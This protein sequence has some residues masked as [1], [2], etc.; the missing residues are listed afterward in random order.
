MESAARRRTW[1]LV[2]LAAAILTT[3]TVFVSASADAPAIS[4]FQLDRIRAK[5]KPVKT[6]VL[7]AAV[8]RRPSAPVS[9]RYQAAPE[10]PE[11]N[12][13]GGIDW[14]PSK[15]PGPD[16]TDG[17]VQLPTL[18]VNAPIVRVGI[19]SEY[20][21]VVPHNARDVAWLD[22]GGI[23]GSTNNVVLAGHIAYSHVAGSFFRIG[24]LRPRDDVL[25]KMDGK[26][27]H[28]KVVWNC[29]FARDASA[30]LALKIMGYTDVPSVTL[31]SCGGGWDPVARTHTRRTA[32]RAE[33]WPPQKA[34]DTTA[35]K[36]PAHDGLLPA[37]RP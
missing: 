17:S 6:K 19:D 28:Y 36:H 2:A 37:G 35:E 1:G 31:I 32:V 16:P 26:T 25:L 9:G 13:P 18:G 22:Q 33:L 34:G 29:S 12:N 5:P 8:E 20:H 3:T 24:D 4:S 7:A 11:M 30:D 27:W 14:S 21:M 15:D 10:C 23:P